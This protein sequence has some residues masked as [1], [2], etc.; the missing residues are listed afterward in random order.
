MSSFCRTKIYLLCLLMAYFLVCLVLFLEMNSYLIELNLWDPYQIV[1]VRP[2]IY[3]CRSQGASLFW[4]HFGLVEDSGPNAGG[5][6][7]TPGLQKAPGEPEPLCWCL[8]VQLT[9][10]PGSI[11]PS[12]AILAHTLA[13]NSQVRFSQWSFFIDCLWWGAGGWGGFLLLS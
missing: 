6:G 10:R 12:L 11:P 5:S 2:C 4:E 7:Q 8:Q 3:S 13:Y 1:P 9:L